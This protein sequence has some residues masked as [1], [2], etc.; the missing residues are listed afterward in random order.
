MNE[1]IYDISD[2]IDDCYDF[3]KLDSFLHTFY[4]NSL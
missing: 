3:I 1:K 2:L 4:N